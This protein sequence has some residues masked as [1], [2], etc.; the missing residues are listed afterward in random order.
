M[1]YHTHTNN[2][3]LDNKI[4]N[5][6]IYVRLSRDDGD[7]KE[8]ESIE[9][10]KDYCSRYVQDNGWNIVQYYADDGY[11]G[12]NFDRPAFKRLITDIES[13]MVNAVITKDLS[14][15]GRDYI[16][17]GEYLERYFPTNNIRYI[18]INDGIDTFI[19]SSNNDM[20]PFRSVINDMYARDISK[21]VC[22]VMK[23]KQS[24][25]KFIGS[26]APYG[27]LKDPQNKN[28]LIVDSNV[29]NIIKRIYHMF[30][31]G[32]GYTRIAHAFNAEGIKCPSAYK[33]EIYTNYYNPK[34][35][36]GL[37]TAHTIKSILVNPTYIGNLA[38]G[39]FKKVNYKVKKLKVIPRNDW[40]VIKDTHEAIVDEDAFVIAQQI[41]GNSNTKSYAKCKEEH[42]LTGF[43]YCGDCGERITFIKNQSKKMYC[44]CSKYKRFG[45]KYCSR[46]SISENLLEDK[47][48]ADLYNIANYTLNKDMLDELS[49]SKTF[50]N[51]EI[52][53]RMQVTKLNNK[54]DE[55]KRTIKSLYEDK[56]KGTIEETDFID[57]S[58]SFGK[59][60]EVVTNR[61]KVMQ[62]EIDKIN[63]YKNGSDD[64]LDF[65]KQFTCFDNLD[66]FTL[67]KLVDK[68]EI[69]ENQKVVVHYKFKRP[70]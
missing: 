68:I 50:K 58:K 44:I 48:K 24:Q 62:K 22:T 32:Y 57:L 36:V 55:I 9:N 2:L 34:V 45:K 11:S 29:S 61:L 66:R 41:I 4:Y 30:I 26:F 54:L 52:N 42:L 16:G 14:R 12:T 46:H 53:L 21:K 35:K 3:N 27:Y 10:Q 15:L 8:S 49:K 31:N 23:T 40:I 39:K 60:R 38:Q 28:K 37:W 7:A 51:K 65:I 70:Y 19:D 18:A 56:L 33:K 13:G 20:S 6:G 17:T 59:E 69:F 43:M 47:L 64:L 25:G 1:N 67:S 63:S 5:V